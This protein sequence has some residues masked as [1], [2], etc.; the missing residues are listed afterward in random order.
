MFFDSAEKHF[1]TLFH[2]SHM[3]LFLFCLRIIIKILE[4]FIKLK[5]KLYTE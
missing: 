2:S 1:G 3:Y 4:L 5:K